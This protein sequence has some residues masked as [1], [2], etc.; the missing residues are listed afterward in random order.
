MLPNNPLRL[1]FKTWRND[2]GL[3]TSIQNRGCAFS[4]ATPTSFNTARASLST[5]AVRL[6]VRGSCAVWFSDMDRITAS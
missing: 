3:I 1:L 4:P 6:I 2:T 5:W